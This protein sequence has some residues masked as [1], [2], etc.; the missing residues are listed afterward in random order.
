MWELQR[1]FNNSQTV[2]NI[3]NSN[4]IPFEIAT[5]IKKHMDIK[6]S[7]SRYSIQFSNNEI[8]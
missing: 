2:K 1:T 4:K 7:K 8:N 3:K 5:V 6:G